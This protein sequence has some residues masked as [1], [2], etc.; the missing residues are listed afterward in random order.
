M[1]KLSPRAL[2]FILLYS[3][4]GWNVGVQS[5]AVVQGLAN[6]VIKGVFFQDYLKK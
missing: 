1:S 3:S 2:F 4:D 6:D 5:S